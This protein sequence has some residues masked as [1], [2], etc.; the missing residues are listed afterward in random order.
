MTSLAPKRI[1]AAV[2]SERPTE[3]LLRAWIVPGQVHA[4]TR[5]KWYRQNQE[6]HQR[7]ANSS[8]LALSELGWAHSSRPS[9]WFA[10][11]FVRLVGGQKATSIN[12]EKPG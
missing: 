2:A 10:G 1:L 6:L 8:V 11:G 5:T 12:K 9:G 4:I 7:Y 3:A